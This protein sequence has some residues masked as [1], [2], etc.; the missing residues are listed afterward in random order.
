MQLVATALDTTGLETSTHPE[1]C[2]WYIFRGKNG[3]WRILCSKSSCLR[4]KPRHVVIYACMGLYE[5][6]ERWQSIYTSGFNT[7]CS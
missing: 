6:E 4:R 5:H 3:K 1:G 7:S 2:P